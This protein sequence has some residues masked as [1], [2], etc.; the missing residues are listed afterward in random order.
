M[1]RASVNRDQFVL[2]PDGIV[3]KP[4]N[5][6]FTA[7]PADPHSGIIRLGDLPYRHPNEG[8]FKPDDVCRVMI[9]LWVDYVANNPKLFRR[10]DRKPT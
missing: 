8:G 1:L 4:T 2:S 7:D 3:H 10:V 9:E 6:A 5:A